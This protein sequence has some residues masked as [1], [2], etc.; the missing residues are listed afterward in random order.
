MKM[1]STYPNTIVFDK[2]LTVRG[3]LSPDTNNL[4]ESSLYI[5]SHFPVK[6]MVNTQKRGPW[7]I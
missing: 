4:F 1:L 7:P 3:I 5:I 2:I 6:G